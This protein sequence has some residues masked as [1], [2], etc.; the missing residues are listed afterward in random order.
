LPEPVAVARR[1]HQKV[2]GRSDDRAKF[3]IVARIRHEN[4]LET[5]CS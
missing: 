1:Q 3:I 4:G 2:S 5:R